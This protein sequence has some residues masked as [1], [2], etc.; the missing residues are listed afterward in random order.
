MIAFLTVND[1]RQRDL[2]LRKRMKLKK[3][4]KLKKI[5]GYMLVLAIIVACHYIV[6]V[7]FA[8]SSSSDSQDWAIN[9]LISIAQDMGV[10]QLIKILVTVI[11]LKFVVTIQS[12]KWKKVLRLL[13]DKVIMRSIAMSTMD[14]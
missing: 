2:E 14:N 4:G 6:L 13:S 3:T 10:S 9:L 8:N 7:I 12:E 5:V 11:C 1:P